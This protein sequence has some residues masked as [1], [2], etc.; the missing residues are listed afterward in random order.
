MIIDYGLLI[1]DAD[2]GDFLNSGYCLFING[3]LGLIFRVFLKNC[4]EWE[5]WV[6]GWIL[7]YIITGL[8]VGATIW[9]RGKKMVK[10]K[11]AAKKKAK[12]KAK[13]AKRKKK[14]GPGGGR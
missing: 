4:K 9:E 10:K 1:I 3:G 2:R 8:K 5:I 12:K 14:G 11:K 7:S 6:D 13:R